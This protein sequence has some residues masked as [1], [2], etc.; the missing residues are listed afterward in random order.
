MEGLCGYRIGL[1]NGVVVVEDVFAIL[2]LGGVWLAVGIIHGG[3][4]RRCLFYW[5]GVHTVC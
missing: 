5:V 2:V 4:T 3:A 1:S